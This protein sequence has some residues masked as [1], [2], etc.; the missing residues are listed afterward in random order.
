MN[1][2]P[3]AESDALGVA[4]VHVHTWQAAYRGVVSDAYLESLSV[5]K[6][7]LVWRESIV[8]GTPELWVADSGFEIVGW[9]AFGKSRDVDAAGDVGELEAI[10]V[11][12]AFWS[13]GLG[14]SLWLTVRR[15]LIERRFSSATLWV[16]KDNLRA[17]R[18]YQAAGFEEESA[19]EKE[20]LIGGQKFQEVRYAASFIL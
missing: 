18:F 3:A 6:R 16:L 15:R 5:G 4:Q 20:I 14:R 13:K 7:E 8:K 9:A 11:L 19:S 17:I 1:L 12:P 2:R 10:Y